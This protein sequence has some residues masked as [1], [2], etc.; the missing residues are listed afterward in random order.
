V[1]EENA[2]SFVVGGYCLRE[3]LLREEGRLKQDS[4]CLLF[5]VAHRLSLVSISSALRS[6]LTR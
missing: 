5:V 2:S 1:I 6:V 3:V 4:V